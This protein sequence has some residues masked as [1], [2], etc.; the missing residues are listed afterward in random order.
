MADLQ[1]ANTNLTKNCRRRR[2]GKHFIRYNMCAFHSPYHPSAILGS[3]DENAAR[4][5]LPQSVAGHS[6]LDAD[7]THLGQRD[8]SWTPTGIRH[9]LS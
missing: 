9:G 1:A 3:D 6:V 2:P 7:A 5:V 8:F 4:S